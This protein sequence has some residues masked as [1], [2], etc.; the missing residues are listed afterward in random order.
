MIALI[1]SGEARELFCMC[2]PI[3]VTAIDDGTAY[4]RG[5]TVHVLGGG[6]CNDVATPFNRAAVDGRG[7]GIIDNKGYTVLMSQLS[8]ALDIKNITAWVGNGLAKETLGVRTEG[9]FNALIIPIG[10]NEG[11]VDT[12]LLHGNA[13]EVV[14]ATIYIIRGDEVVAC[15]TDIK[16]GIEAGSLA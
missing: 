11:A 13:K 4:L 12:E 16:D 1:G 8:E 5:M 2:L 7:K 14:R 3:E 10:I 9:C 6:V 15:L